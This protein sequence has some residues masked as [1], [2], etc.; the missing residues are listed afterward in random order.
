[1]DDKYPQSGFKLNFLEVVDDGMTAA[2]TARILGRPG[3][4][5]SYQKKCP[6]KIFEEASTGLSK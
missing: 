6:F 3:L 1:M 5:F 4:F 2:S